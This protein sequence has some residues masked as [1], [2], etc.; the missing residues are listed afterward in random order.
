[1]NLVLL[2]VLQL[3][4]TKGFEKKKKH[5]SNCAGGKRDQSIKMPDFHCHL[6]PRPQVLI[7]IDC[8]LDSLF[9]HSPQ[10]KS[11]AVL[12]NSL[13]VQLRFVHVTLLHLSACFFINMVEG[14]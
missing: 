2:L 7:P 12:V 3:C 13:L 6:I 4:M 10:L 11:I 5:F 1:M 14:K 9:H 8:Q